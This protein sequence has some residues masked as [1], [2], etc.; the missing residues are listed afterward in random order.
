MSK[1]KVNL[2]VCD[3]STMKA[4]IEE[5]LDWRDDITR[6]FSDPASLIDSSGAVGFESSS[7]FAS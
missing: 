6:I 4:V 1:S 2:I 7:G 5:F 3:V